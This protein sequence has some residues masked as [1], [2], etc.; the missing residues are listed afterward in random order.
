M[1]AK[2]GSQALLPCLCSMSSCHPVAV[3][4]SKDKGWEEIEFAPYFSMPLQIHF[5][6]TFASKYRVSLCMSVTVSCCGDTG[7][8]GERKGAV[9]STGVRAGLRGGTSGCKAS[10]PSLTMAITAYISPV[11]QMM[12]EGFSLVGWS[13]ETEL[14]KSRLCSE[15]C[16]VGKHLFIYFV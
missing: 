3:I 14:C 2:V 6:F 13:L 9:C 5:L 15:L 4:W 11:W 1:F 10:T 8:F 7:L 16:K 12:M